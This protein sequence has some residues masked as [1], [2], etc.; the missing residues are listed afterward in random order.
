MAD[1]FEAAIT[2]YNS[3]YDAATHQNLYHAT[4]I[5]G[6]SWYSQQ[7]TAAE[8]AG[9]RYARAYKIRIPAGAR[10]AKSFVHPSQYTDPA[11]QYTLKDGD[12]IVKGLTGYLPD[13]PEKWAAM[14]KLFPEMATV[15]GY[16]D[17][18]RGPLPHIYVRGE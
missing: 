8:N 16:H 4:A 3:T 15:K 11:T 9:A 7:D 12:R 5:E 10:C 14:V 18:R 17:N 1:T 13:T 6:V 2:V